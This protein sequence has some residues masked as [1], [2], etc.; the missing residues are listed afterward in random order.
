[1]N[2]IIPTIRAEGLKLRRSPIFP[3]SILLFVFIPLMMG[4]MMYVSR[5][6]ELSGRLGIAGSK[7]A[8]FGDSD[9]PAFFRLLTLSIALIGLIGFG[10]IISWVFGRE[11]SD[12]TVRELLALPVPRGSIVLA[13]FVVIAVL[14]IFLSLVSLISGLV[15]GGAIQLPGW[16]NELAVQSATIFIGTCILTI[17][18]STPVAFFACYGR[19]Y[20]PPMGFVILTLIV[21]QFIALVGLG[22]YFPWAIPTLYTGAGGVGTVGIVS[23]G[24]L[25][26]TALAGFAGTVAWW[27]LADHS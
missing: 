6:P 2:S 26:V 18:V 23:Y 21:A 24:I 15:I 8:L 3:I 5:D 7:V 11:Y 27:Y 20:L 19:G 12:G 13:K 25:F 1:M 14:C 22:L 17:A 16:T 10:F 9:W 4:L